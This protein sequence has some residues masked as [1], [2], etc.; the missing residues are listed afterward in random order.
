MSVDHLSARDCPT[1]LKA[2]PEFLRVKPGDV[3]V[4][5]TVQPVA[6][7]QTNAWWMGQVIFC[8]GGARDPLVN[9]MFQVADVDNGCITWVNA[10]AVTHILG[11][12]EAIS[13]ST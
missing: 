8:E 4:V 13:A 10:D 2:P 5:K 9:T 1:A 6:H 3:V 7:G 11:S 12:A